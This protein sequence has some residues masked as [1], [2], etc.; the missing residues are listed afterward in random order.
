MDKF[1]RNYRITID[2]GDGSDAIVITMPITVRFD[3]QRSITSQLNNFNIDIY[4]L[5]KSVRDRIYQDWFGIPNRQRKIKFEVGYDSLTEIFYG[6]I[7]SAYSERDGVNIVT[8]IESHD[9]YFGVSENTIF[10]TYQAGGTTRDLLLYLIGK[11]Q[12]VELGAVGN[13]DTPI[14]NPVVLNGNVWDIIRNLCDNECFIDLNKVYCV[15]PNEI[16]QGETA[17]IDASTGL[18]GTPKREEASLSVTTLLDSRI[19]VGRKVKLDSSILPVFNGEYRV[20]TINHRGVISEA[21]C[22]QATTTLGLFTDTKLFG[23][24]VVVSNDSTGRLQ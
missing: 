4:N 11:L 16:L 21:E 17:I 14:T 12:P 19:N 15:K 18:L 7:Y 1:G 5:S 9:G 3:I 2:M 6:S 20:D 23:E 8:H 10:E 24:F 13:Y 22:G